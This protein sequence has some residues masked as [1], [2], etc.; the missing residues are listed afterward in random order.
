[1][2]GYFIAKNIFV[3]EVA[4]KLS[5][6]WNKFINFQRKCF[7]EQPINKVKKYKF[8]QELCF[9]KLPLKQC[10]NL[11]RTCSACKA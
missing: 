5:E 10:E 7:V 1:M 6:I 3:A 8:L 9:N 2:K 11:P 4:F